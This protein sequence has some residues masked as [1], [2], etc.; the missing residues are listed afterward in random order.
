MSNIIRVQKSDNYVV[1]NK[2]SLNDKR[3][4]WKAKGLHAFML[5]KPNNW[6]FYDS[7][8]V[9]HAKDGID[10]LKS[11]LKE[12]K[13]YGYMKRI[14]HRDENGRFV[15]ETVVYEVPCRENPSMEKPLV[16]NPSMEK[17][18]MDSPLMENPQ[19]LNNDLLNNDLLSNDQLNNNQL[20]NDLSIMEKNIQKLDIPVVIKKQMQKEI[21]RLIDDKINLEDIEIVY[22]SVKDDLTEYQ[23]ADI[24]STVLR[25]TKEK[26]INIKNLLHTAIRNYKQSKV[27]HME[28]SVKR[29]VRTAPLPKWMTEKKEP[30]PVPADF[31][32]K[33]KE[34][35]EMLKNLH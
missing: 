22:Q 28:E 11:A 31:E 21:D 14:R 19:L 4:S 1:M 7:E 12:L 8:L 5:S 29:N 9:E 20:N 35:E 24:L 30:K 33:K 3:L 23:F 34:L 27:I 18:L 17:P 10:S 25:E 6:K 16:E 26:I 15:W 32:R 2:E 13:K